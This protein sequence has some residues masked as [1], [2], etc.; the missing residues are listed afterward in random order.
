[1]CRIQKTD[2]LLNVVTPLL[3][4]TAIYFTAN[5]IVLNKFIRNG[6]PDGLWSYALASCILIIWNRKMNIFWM[7][8]IFLFYVLFEILQYLNIIDGTGDYLDII[9]YFGFSIIPLLT[10]KYFITV[11]KN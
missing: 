5:F 11:F 2:L 1:M 10:N 3:A 9:I 8:L 7:V 6:L 4:G